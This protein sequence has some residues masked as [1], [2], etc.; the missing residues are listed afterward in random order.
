MSSKSTIF[1][2][3]DNEHCYE[4]CN[5]PEFVN[6]IFIGN[7]II[8][9]ISKKNIDILCNDTDDLI[10]EIKPGSELYNIIKNIKLKT[11]E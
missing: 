11:N 5:S 6:D 3:K 10:L 9:E 1:L 8:F 4:E 7:A 2:T